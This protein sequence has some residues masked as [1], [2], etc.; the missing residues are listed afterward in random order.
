MFRK[1]HKPL[2]P[3]SISHGF[4]S[5]QSILEEIRRGRMVIVCDD[6]DREAEGDLMMAA[7][8]V[9][10]EDVNF[11]ATHGRGLV[12]LPMHPGMVERLEIPD[13]VERNDARLGTAFTVP[14]EASEGVTTGISAADRAHTI[15]VAVD[16]DSGPDDLVMPGHVFPLKAKP[17]GVLQRA[18]HT[19]A[20]VDLAQL[21][22]LTP[23]GVICEVM[24]GDGTMAR[25]SRLESF[26]DHHGLMMT[27]VARIVEH[28]R[29]YAEKADLIVGSKTPL[30]KV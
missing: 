2:L 14:I 7:E 19:E 21:A 17:G 25:V 20:A 8:L 6:D 18:G 16:P 12:C 4:S 11:M 5:V 22:G 1:V 23:A 15:R 28:R 27:S 30:G 3:D 9:T 10:P 24:N 29:G 26:T 13:M